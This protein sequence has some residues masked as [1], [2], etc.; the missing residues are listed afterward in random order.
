M[1]PYKLATAFLHSWGTGSFVCTS[2]CD[3]VLCGLKQVQ[4]LTVDSTLHIDSDVF[5]MYGST[6]VAFGGSPPDWAFVFFPISERSMTL[7]G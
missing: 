4:M 3:S 6:T 1:E 7:E 5:L 2:T